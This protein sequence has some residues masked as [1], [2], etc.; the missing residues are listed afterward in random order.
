MGTH[1]TVIETLFLY[2]VPYIYYIFLS[3]VFANNYIDKNLETLYNSAWVQMR[4]SFWH[5][6]AEVCHNKP[7]KKNI[8]EYNH[9]HIHPG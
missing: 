1:S 3:L 9:Q 6:E 4:F 2:S 5:N 8:N 7:S